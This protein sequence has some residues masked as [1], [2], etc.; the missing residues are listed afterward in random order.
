MAETKARFLADTQK[1]DTTSEAFTWPTGRATT[2]NY[3][4][5]MT[6]KDAGTTGWQATATAPVIT[7]VS[8]LLN[9]DSDS[10]LTIVGSDFKTTTTVKLYDADAGGN[11]VASSSSLNTSGI[12]TKLVATFGHANLTKNATL[13]VETANSGITARHSTGITVSGDPIGAGSTSSDWFS[14]ATG[15]N[16]NTST[17]LGT[18]TGEVGGNDSNTEV[19]LN[20][21]KG[22]GTTITND[23]SGGSHAVTANGNAII[24]A[25]PFGDG[26]SAIYTPDASYLKVDSHADFAFGAVSATTND[27]TV[28]SWH[29]FSSV[30]DDKAVWTFGTDS[31]LCLRLSGTAYLQFKA[32]GNTVGLD[33]SSDI[34]HGFSTGIWY[35][36]ALVRSGST[37]SL[38]I[39][40]QLKGST[41]TA[42]NIEARDFYINRFETN[43]YNNQYVD[44]IRI[45]KGT[46][47]YTGNFTVPTSR[48][49]AT[50]SAGTNISA[51]PATGTK[52]L[53]HSDINFNEKSSK[54]PTKYGSGS[55]FETVAGTSGQAEGHSFSSRVLGFN[56]SSNSAYYEYT[57][58][59]IGLGTNDNWMVDFWVKTTSTDPTDNWIWQIAPKASLGG[60]TQFGFREDGASSTGGGIDIRW[61]SV[62]V[63]NRDQADGF[64]SNTWDHWAVVRD[65]STMRLYKNANYVGA[66]TE[67][68]A[69]FSALD[70]DTLTLRLGVLAS[71]SINTYFSEFRIVVGESIWNHTNSTSGNLMSASYDATSTDS[72]NATLLPSNASNIKFLYTGSHRI[73]DSLSSAKTVTV[74]G[75]YHSQFH[76]GI[77]TAMAWPNN[78]KTFGS[79]GVYFDGT[80]DYLSLPDHADLQWGSDSFS[81]DFWMYLSSLP[82]GSS[83]NNGYMIMFNGNDAGDTVNWELQL[84]A[85]VGL[86]MSGSGGFSGANE[87]NMNDW[88][89]HRWYHIA[90]SRNGTSTFKVYRDG[91]RIINQTSGLSASSGSSYGIKIGGY[92]TS[93]NNNYNTTGY[94]GYLDSIRIQKGVVAFTGDNTSSANFTLPT[95]IYGGTSPKNIP[96]IVFAGTATSPSLAG[97]EDLHFTEVE[98][99]NNATNQKKLSELGLTIDNTYGNANQASLT[100]TLNVADSTTVNYLGVKVQVRKTLSNSAGTSGQATITFSGGTD[101]AGLSPDMVVTGTGI[102][103]SET[104]ITS[105]DS[106]TQITVNNNHAGTVSGDLIFYDPDR[107]HFINKG[108]DSNVWDNPTSGGLSI[109]G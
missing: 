41:T 58:G 86:M 68:V 96:T 78:L 22:G 106:S 81:I 49:S 99:T 46:A 30:S 8:G 61:G 92:S 101:T 69:D 66:N 16:A 38:Y 76:G 34:Q 57:L 5:A 98:N 48:L 6:D 54:H 93:V 45:V 102:N 50:Q 79:A 72:T 1:A 85:S 89:P 103:A 55:S 29:N 3:V 28:E 62:Y 11:L 107:V 31:E 90:I 39:D 14:G 71:H 2:D 19:L 26:K 25:S 20:F 73:K 84:D 83:G 24:K 23:A 60:G 15:T 82:S 56:S 44:E 7:S 75:S 18:Y 100:G 109:Q 9:D 10:T 33:G 59:N 80:A 95:Q 74:T 70:D 67:T 53:I 51:I 37:T 47:V 108:G 27:F 52:L 35:H 97:D 105:V 104:K 42:Y 88:Q 36:I 87:G 91:V 13:Y 77:D 4:L 40:G 43:K 94:H 12:P 63:I 32:E 21:D 17:H 65:G 64:S